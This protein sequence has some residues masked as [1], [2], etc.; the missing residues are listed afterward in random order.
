LATPFLEPV[1]GP[2]VIFNEEPSE[3]FFFGRIPSLPNRFMQKGGV[4][5]NELHLV[6]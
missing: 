5:A 4:E 3:E 1:D 2:Y 6:S